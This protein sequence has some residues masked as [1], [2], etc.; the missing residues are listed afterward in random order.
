MALDFSG[1]PILYSWQ[2]PLVRRMVDIVRTKRVC[3]NLSEMGTG[4]TVQTVAACKVLYK[5]PF[6][7]CPKSVMCT[8]KQVCD[9][10]DVKPIAIVNY[11]TIKLGKIY[12]GNT[13]ASTA[14]VTKSSGQYNWALPFDACL[15]MDEVHKCK[16]LKTDNGKLLLS[17]KQCPAVIL[18]TGT[19]VESLDEIKPFAYV[20]NEIGDLRNFNSYKKIHGLARCRQKLND[21]IVQIKICEIDSFPSNHVMIKTFTGSDLITK[22]YLK[23]KE[24][25]AKKQT[26]HV[27][28]DIQKHKQQIELAKT[29]IFVEQAQSYLNE[30][31]SVVIFVNY[32]DTMT[33]IMDALGT[34]CFINGKQTIEQRQECQQAFQADQVRIIVCQMRVI[35][36]D[37][38]DVTGKHPRATLLSIPDSGTDL[39]QVLGRTHRA[40]G[41]SSVVQ[42]I[43]VTE[44]PYEQEMIDSL[45]AKV[46]N[47]ACIHGRTNSY[48]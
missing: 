18:L 19:I 24:L 9:W 12:Y 4:K 28:S 14:Y 5:R 44:D 20:C 1:V 21:F 31:K 47:I 11:E 42:T 27:L 17:A 2:E 8:W 23:I 35:G 15:I 37:L 40:G 25:L 29:G 16:N 34:D 36:V 33:V 7:I 10:F 41:K 45:V 26:S 3:L 30:G 32:L 43:V 48:L 13:R 22:E 6:I 39:E 38:H 46:S